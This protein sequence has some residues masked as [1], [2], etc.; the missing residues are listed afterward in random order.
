MDLIDKFLHLQQSLVKLG[1]QDGNLE[2]DAGHKIKAILRSCCQQLKVSRVSLWGFNNDKKSILCHD[3]YIQ[4]EDSFQQGL[5]IDD[6]S[7]PHY[8]EALKTNRVINVDHA[9]TDVRTNEFLASYLKPLNI[10]SMLDAP[11]FRNGELTGVIC[12]EQCGHQ[13]SWDMAEISYCV[14]VADT[15]SLIYAQSDWFVEKQKMRYMERID[16]LTN[17]ENRLFFQ[18]RIDQAIHSSIESYECAVILIGLDSFTNINDRFGYSFANKLLTEI[19]NRLESIDTVLN[20]NLSRV[21]GDIFAF[22]VT[23]IKHDS[24][25]HEFLEKLENVFKKT[26]KS[27]CGELIQVSAG[28]G[29]LKG[30]L[31]ELVNSHPIRRAEL[32]MLKAKERLPRTVCYFEPS[33]LKKLQQELA[34]EA[35]FRKAI[36]NGQIVPHYQPIVAETYKTSGFSLEALVRW[37]HPSKGI[38]SPQIILPIAKRLGVM[39]E[40]GDVVLK[41][42]C[43]DIKRFLDMGLDLKKVSVNIS[44]E[45]LFNAHFIQQIQSYLKVYKISHSLLEFEIIE[46]LIAGDSIIL[47]KQLEQITKLGINLSI[48]DFGTGYSSLSRLKH[49]NVSKLKIDKSFVDGLPTNEDDICIAQSIIGLAKGMGLQIV[50]EGVE[51]TEQANWLYV[52]GCEFIQGYLISKPMNADAVFEFFAAKP[53]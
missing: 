21:G 29:V 9:R 49:L 26:V 45:Q 1:F 30:Q 14:S 42:A 15:I 5:R 46:E 23:R 18:K 32:A 13:K 11:I 25:L 31:N 8:F 33:W 52:N 41:Q 48:D 6:S 40:V 44:S 22:W 4:A 24:S 36:K 35:D 17:L 34:F 20:A 28:I 51:T 2:Q 16:P 47:T 38:L 27:P 53:S 39:K 10:H 43:H 12:I 37:E 3:L 19:A 7:C 50:A